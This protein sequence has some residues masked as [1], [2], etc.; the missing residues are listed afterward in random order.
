MR[1]PEEFAGQGLERAELVMMLPADWSLHSQEERWYWPLRWL[2][3]LARLPEEEGAWLGWGHTVPNGEAFAENTR[4]SSVLLLG[5]YLAQGIAAP[6]VLETAEPC[7]FL[8]PDGEQVRFYQVF[9]LYEEELQ[10][11]LTHG[12]PALLERFSGGLRPVLELSRENVC[13]FLQA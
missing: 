1:L 12:V 6:A 9:P 5:A 13:A 7:M 11:K 8:L 2:K 3:L 4:L 10:Y